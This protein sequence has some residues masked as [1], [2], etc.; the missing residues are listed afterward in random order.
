M[1][2]APPRDPLVGRLV[3]HY[4]I[5]RPLGAGGMGAVYLAERA[6][7]EFRRQVAVKVLRPGLEREDILGR[8]LVERQTL[9]ALEHPNIVRLLDGGSTEDGRPYLVMDYVEGDS[10]EDYAN[11]RGLGV[12]A[13]LELFRQVCAA[14]HYAH[15]HLVVHRDLKPGNILVT[16]EGT[17]KLL[18]FGIAKILTPDQPE[19][20]AG[21]TVAGSRPMTPQYA[22]PEQILGQPITTASDTYALG[23]M[24][25]RLLTGR[26]PYEFTTGAEAELVELICQREP[27]RPSALV[28]RLSRASDQA[29]RIG[30]R[31]GE[32][33]ARALSGELDLVVMMALRKEPQRRYL[34]VE[35]FAEDLRRYAQGLPVTAHRDTLRYR[36]RKFVERHRAG[37]AAAALAAVVL[38]T[39][40]VVSLEQKR[41][42]ERRF[43]EVRELARFV[44][45][46]FDDVIRSGVT[47]ARKKMVERA[48]V[49]L[50]RLALESAHDVSLQRELMDGY[51]KVGD[52][53][54]NLY[55]P[56]VGDTVGARESYRRALEL[57]RQVHADQPHEPA[58]RRY[59][60]RAN[61]KLGDLSALGGDR[62]EALQQYQEALQ[63]LDALAAAQPG[64][65]AASRE[66]LDVAG[67]IGFTHYQ[68]GNLTAALASY[69]RCLLIAQEWQKAEPQARGA[70]RAVASGHER[71]GE[72][73]A[74]SGRTA[75]GL[76][77][78]RAA[79]DIYQTLRA[80]HPADPQAQRD[81]SATH[82][83]VGDILLGA[84]RT[85]EALESYR[86]GLALA[87][88]MA[89]DD[90]ENKLARTD[91]HL[92]LGRLADVLWAAGQKPQAREMTERALRVLKPL[93]DSPDALQYDLQNYAWILATTPFEDLR[94]PA[95][96]EQSALKTVEMTQWSDPRVL[97][98]LARAYEAGGKVERALEAGEKALSLLPPQERGGAASDLRKELARS[99]TSNRPA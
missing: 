15:Q 97:D 64:D 6:G 25:Y 14:V 92:T 38:V 70:R 39:S 10:I 34:S 13:R 84:G 53:Q 94:D 72:V 62:R 83:I 32:A 1:E 20:L 95:R 55:G 5:L 71:V 45:Y 57:A 63:V 80:E 18:D 74:R 79:L 65:L 61:V 40:T 17:P 89:R 76:V 91:L 29:P 78:L 46:E 88:A 67:K 8:F 99:S 36:A 51:F 47:A 66:V 68:L 73:L 77:N 69:R 50:N 3:G 41:R 19:K 90:P 23:V 87:E 44:L 2:S 27:E 52:V 30:G 49:Y 28:R 81:V 93:A 9:A 12:E 43:Q 24:L 42:A 54:G 26:H 96:A 85:P 31:Q 60:A 35:H 56:N 59:L 21:L 33:L 58:S 11:A 48:L 82:T 37:V 98:T 4:R 22:S 7:P 16:Q 75:E 86:L